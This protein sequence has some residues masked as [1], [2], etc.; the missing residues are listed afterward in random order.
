MTT[1]W[2]RL[3]TA[4]YLVKY[5]NPLIQLHLET[6]KLKGNRNS[7]ALFFLSILLIMPNI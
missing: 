5:I 1:L 7:K 2:N 4:E 3:N 6:I